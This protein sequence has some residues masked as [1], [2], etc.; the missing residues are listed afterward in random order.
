M[1]EVEAR[2]GEPVEALLNR[3]Y[4]K[5]NKTMRE[6]AQILGVRSDSTVWL[7]L[8]KFEIPTRRWMLPDDAT[9]QR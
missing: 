2:F 9:E 6:V 7:W 5:E 8:L 1:R 3:L 4:I